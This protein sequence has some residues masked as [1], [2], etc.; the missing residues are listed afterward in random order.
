ML[1]REKT[2]SY[3]ELSSDSRKE[4]VESYFFE[5]FEYWNL[6]DFVY[7]SNI[8]D[9]IE[10]EVQISNECHDLVE[11]SR[12]IRPFSFNF[13]TNKNTND[14]LDFVIRSNS[15]WLLVSFF[16]E[17]IISFEKKKKS[18]NNEL[19]CMTHFNFVDTSVWT[20]HRVIVPNTLIFISM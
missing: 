5:F 14:S 7:I 2:Q 20:S 10:F 15:T 6:N 3:A 19:F 12:L 1:R 16:F 11:V 17:A 9:S 18:P 4:K 8:V 13:Y